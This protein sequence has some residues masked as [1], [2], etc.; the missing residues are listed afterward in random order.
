MSRTAVLLAL[1]LLGCGQDPTATLHDRLAAHPP[2]VVGALAGTPAKA[3][4][5]A[6]A[7]AVP[8]QNTLLLDGL[9]NSGF[10]LLADGRSK[11]PR[12]GAYWVGACAETEADPH[13]VVVAAD[14]AFRGERFLHLPAG[15]EVQQKIVAAP[16]NTSNLRVSVAMRGVAAQLSLVLEDGSGQ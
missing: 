3:A 7:P 16:D 12:Y 2:V 5:T 13:A 9:L 6:S 15:S 10:E 1:A 8:D 11:P 4:P 14:D